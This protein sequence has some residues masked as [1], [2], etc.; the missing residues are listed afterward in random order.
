MASG[1]VTAV[2]LATVAIGMIEALNP[3]INAVICKDYERALKC[4]AQPS[5]GPLAGVPFLLKD[6]YLYTDGM[7]TTWGSKFFQ[8]TRPRA[9]STMVSQWRAAGLTILGKTNAPEF[10]SEFVTDPAAYGRTINPWDA[11]VTVGGSSGGA[12]AAVS[13]GMVPLAHATDLGGSIRVPAACCGLYG[14]K[15]TAGLNSSGPYFK[16]IAHGL[17]SD[18]VVTR[19]VRDS[20]ASLDITAG[21]GRGNYLAGHLAQP[22]KLKIAATVHGADG[23]V[24]DHLQVRA[25]EDV[26]ARL[27][28][29]GHD[30]HL[31]ENS[32]FIAVG[33]WFDLLWIDDIPR[34]LADEAGY[35]CREPMP[36]ELEPFTLVAL[37]LL[38]AAGPA[39]VERAIRMMAEAARSHLQL[40]ETYDVLLTPSLACDPAPV[41][42]LGFNDLGTMA[43]WA[44]A[45]YGFA[46]FSI[47]ANIAG[48]PAASLPLPL[49][50]SDIPIGVQLM[51]APHR[52]LLVLQLSRQLE[53]SVQWESSYRRMWNK[54]VREMAPS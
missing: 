33:D 41:G 7:P 52:D 16:E 44:A 14:F 20:A 29:H 50:E 10:A 43:N 2:E 30:V 32:P 25:V 18:H 39:G 1:D 40:F 9:D 19:S 34:L 5:T 6:V 42:T 26:V 53:E 8:G 24:A 35:R 23:L 45:G 17:N 47:H 48:Q 28:E 13:S 21:S 4:A 12:A 38:S 49:P 15:P 27:R 46:P 22:R 36:G 54:S 11:N 31:F 3:S 37:D 51:A